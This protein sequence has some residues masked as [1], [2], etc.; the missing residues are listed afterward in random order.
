MEGVSIGWNCNSATAGVSLGFRKTKANGYKTC[1]FDEMITNFDGIIECINDDFKYLCDSNYL[2][3][4]QISPES[5]FLNTH[6]DGDRVIY[7]TKYK[8]IFNHESPGHA[9][10]Y[11]SQEWKNGI[12]HF[13]LNDFEELKTRYNRRINNFKELV[14][15]GNFIKFILTRPDTK[16]TDLDILKS[17]IHKK[18]PNLNFDIVSL[19]CDKKIYEEHLTLMNV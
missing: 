12:N 8:F 10:L 6:K 1:P 14:N 13:V 17:T 4:I 7:N 18:Y 5:T 15:S 19:S 3:I 9:D 16:E 11:K 2:E